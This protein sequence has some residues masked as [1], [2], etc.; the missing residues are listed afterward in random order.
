MILHLYTIIHVVISLVGILTGLVVLLGLLANQR[1]DLW[2]KWFLITTIATSV[3]GFFFPF[4]SFTPAYG[5]GAISLVVLG[6][7]WFAYC[8]RHLVGGWRWVY[9]VTAMIALYLNVFVGIVQSFLKILPLHALA[10]TRSRLFKSRSWLR[11]R[12]SL[13]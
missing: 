2:T 13:S 7:A 12:S 5:V 10:P 1:L 6:L 11:W 4:H 9:V 3:T 8:S